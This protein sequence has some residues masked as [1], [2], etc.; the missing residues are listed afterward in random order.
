[1][2]TRL[3]PLSLILSIALLAGCASVPMAPPDADTSA[4]SF[5]TDPAMAN[6]Y[7][8][9]NESL[10][11]AVKMPVLI[12]N[13]WVADTAADTYIFKKVGPG[14]HVITSKT[15]NDSTVTI[16][17]QAGNNYFVWQEVKMGMFAARSELHVV[18]DA[19]GR[20]GVMECKLVQ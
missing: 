10:G 14:R 6:I 13:V 7:V 19:K 16:E 20:E 18:D 2:S 15:E 17:A 11:A 5:Q 9:R 8:Y 4:K 1:M 3:I 12:D